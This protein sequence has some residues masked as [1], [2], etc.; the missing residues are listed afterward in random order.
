MQLI[1]CFDIIRCCIYVLIAQIS[2]SHMPTSGAVVTGFA[3]LFATVFVKFVALR[4]VVL[5]GE[6]SFQ[7]FEPFRELAKLV[8]RRISRPHRRMQLV[9]GFRKKINCLAQ[10]FLRHVLHCDLQRCNTPHPDRTSPYSA[11]TAKSA[12]PA[13]V[14]LLVLHAHAHAH[15]P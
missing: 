14:S 12:F 3:P 5:L 7:V 1:K 9:E 8:Q 6:A 15:I 10:F 11:Q 13:R 2:Q 4:L